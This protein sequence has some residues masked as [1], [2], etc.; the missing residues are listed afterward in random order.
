MGFHGRVSRSTLADANDTHDWRIYADFA[1]VLIRCGFRRR[2][3]PVP[4]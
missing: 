4:I 1:Q 2:K 3:S